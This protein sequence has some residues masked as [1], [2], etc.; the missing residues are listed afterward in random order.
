M[1]KSFKGIKVAG[2]V[3]AGVTIPF[4]FDQY[5][6]QNYQSGTFKVGVLLAGQ[7]WCQNC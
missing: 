1:R 3:L 2:S 7:G 4:S 6:D 5:I